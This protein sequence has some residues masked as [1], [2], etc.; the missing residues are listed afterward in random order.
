MKRIFTKP[1]RYATCL[2]TTQDIVVKSGLAMTPTKVK[3]LT[4]KGLAVS[5]QSASFYDSSDTSSDWN[6]EPM[7]KRNM[8]VNS[9]W[10]I[11]N[12]SRT[13]VVKAHKTDKKKFGTTK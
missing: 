11:Q 2:A 3:E 10:E 12:E 4:D 8:D 9:L 13:K 1:T 5:N 7:F 6:I